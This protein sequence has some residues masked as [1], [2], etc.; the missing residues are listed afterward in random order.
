VLSRNRSSRT[1][2]LFQIERVHIADIDMELADE[3]RPQPGPVVFE[4][5]AQ[6]VFFPLFR[7]FVVDFP[8]LPIPK[9]LRVAILA[10]RSVSGFPDSPL[11]PAPVPV[12]ES[13]FVIVGVADGVPHLAVRVAGLGPFGR[14]VVVNPVVGVFVLVDV[15]ELV[16]TEVHRVGAE[17]PGA[18]EEVGMEDLHGQADPAS[19]RAAGK[20]RA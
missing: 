2:A 15:D 19:G 16:I 10:D 9:G 6:V 18:A 1:T 14:D 20:H 17:G 4:I 3:L 8:R 12:S 13:P 5:V 11:V 7:D